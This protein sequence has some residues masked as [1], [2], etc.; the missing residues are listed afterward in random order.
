MRQKE[1]SAAIQ[2]GVCSS[3]IYP[4][5]K[6]RGEIADYLCG[7]TPNV[8]IDRENWRLMGAYILEEIPLDEIFL[9]LEVII[10][11]ARVDDIKL[12]NI[13]PPIVV[14]PLT[15]G[16]NRDRYACLDGYHRVTA[17]RERGDE[18]IWAYVGQSGYKKPPK[19]VSSN[20]YRV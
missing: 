13:T 19:L 4:R 15:T 18:T 12:L 20:L 8:V 14:N 16:F 3:I 17:L 10:D 11:R 9:R 7:L 6:S 1:H 5:E 2:E